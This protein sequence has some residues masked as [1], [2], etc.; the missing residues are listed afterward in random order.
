MFKKYTS[1]ENTYRK[2]FLD[3]ILGHELWDKTYII[4]EKAHGANISF[5]TTDGVNFTAAKRTADLQPGE[6]FYNFEQVLEANLN[7]MKAIWLA[8]R[9]EFS[10]LHQL[11]FY[12]E[13]IGGHYPH[14]SVE[15]VKNAIKVQKG[16]SYCPEIRFYAFDIQVNCDSFLDVDRC[17]EL[18]E[19]NNMLYAKSLFEGKLQE[20]LAYNN[21]FDSTIH[22][23][24]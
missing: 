5:W 13:L 2:E 17:N 16:V 12:G 6:K 15:K 23:L 22:A 18:F 7:S 11:T 8:V 14:E 9:E 24:M 19:S 1:I 3:R 21:E 4:Q 10:E 20:C